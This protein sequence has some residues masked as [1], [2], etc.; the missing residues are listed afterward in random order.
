[1]RDV[2]LISIVIRI[3]LS[4]P[5]TIN[6]CRSHVKFKVHLDCYRVFAQL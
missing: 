1:M 6:Q 2:K 5:S 4:L 3:D